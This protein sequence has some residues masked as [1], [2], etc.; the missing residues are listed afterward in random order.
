MLNTFLSGILKSPEIQTALQAPHK[1]MR[2]RVLKENPLKTRRIMLKLNPYAKTMSWN[3]ILHQ[4][5][6]HK[7]RVDKAAA[8]LEAKSDEKR[9]PGKKPVVGK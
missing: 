4:A 5:K 3:T 7:L 8:A 1:K 9:V 2:C 6:N